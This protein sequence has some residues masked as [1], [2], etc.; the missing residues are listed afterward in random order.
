MIKFNTFVLFCH[1][2]DAMASVLQSDYDTNIKLQKQTALP[3]I[4]VG[5]SPLGRIILLISTFDLEELCLADVE[6]DEVDKGKGKEKS[7]ENSPPSSPKPSPRK[8]P[9][10][11]PKKVDKDPAPAPA[12]PKTKKSAGEKKEEKQEKKQEAEEE[13]EEEERQ[14]SEHT[15]SLLLF[16]L[17]FG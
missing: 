4:D 12:D 17:F 11:S 10:N 7:K 2:D 1:R 3:L 9:R 15:K 6:G 8:S 16:F 13:K 5:A 14:N